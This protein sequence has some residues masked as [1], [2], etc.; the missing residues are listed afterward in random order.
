MSRM[1]KSVLAAALLTTGCATKVTRVSHDS[2]IDLTGKWNDTDSRLTAE[3]M[4]KDCLNG[5]WYN[6]FAANKTTPTVVVGEIR[7]KSHEHISTETFINDMQRALINSGKV[8][9]VANKTERGQIRD[10]K[11]DQASNASVQ[12]RQSAGE[13]SGAQLMMIGELNSIVDQEG[14]KAV[15]FYQ[16]NLELVEIESHK[17]LWIGDKKIKKFVERSETK[18]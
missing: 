6:K 13:E 7:N 1:L 8:D 18:F 2:T 14:G 11:S 10:E 5:S 3:E 4:V 15:V 16:V 9:F 12:T 17:K